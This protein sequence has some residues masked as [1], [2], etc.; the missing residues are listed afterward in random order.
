M[1]LFF[2]GGLHLSIVGGLEAN[3]PAENIIRHDDFRKI[4]C[5]WRF[6]PT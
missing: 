5:K 2:I 3:K 1:L 6:D 4:Q